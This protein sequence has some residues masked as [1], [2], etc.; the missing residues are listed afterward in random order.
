VAELMDEV[1]ELVITP[2]VRV[3]DVLVVIERLVVPGAPLE[4]PVAGVEAPVDAAL[5]EAEGVDAD[6]APEARS[7]LTQAPAVSA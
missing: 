2:G 5:D 7:C 3:I 6:V 1:G 4:V